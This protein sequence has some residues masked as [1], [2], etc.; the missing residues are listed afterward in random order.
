MG[1]KSLRRLW[2]PIPLP[3]GRRRPPGQGLRDYSMIDAYLP[4]ATCTPSHHLRPRP[5]TSIALVLAIVAIVAT[6]LAAPHPSPL[7]SQRSRRLRRPRPPP[8]RRR[9]PLVSFASISTSAHVAYCFRT[10]STLFPAS[11]TLLPRAQPSGPK[12][13]VPSAPHGSCAHTERA[14]RRW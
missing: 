1:A 9:Q 4:S 6:S 12:G 14:A 3:R 11:A 2:E 10:S 13:N 5:R 7:L 8:L